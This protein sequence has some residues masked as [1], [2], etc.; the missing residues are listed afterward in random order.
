M[1][2]RALTVSVLTAGLSAGLLAGAL[3]PA[4]AQ[5]NPVGGQGNVYFLSGAGN[6]T[7]QAEKVSVFGD[8]NDEVYFGDWDKD[9]TDSPMVR[10]GN[11]FYVADEDGK[12]VSV[13]AYGD[14]G[15]Q[16]LIG[17]WNG[18]GVDSIAV[19]RANKFFVKNDNQ[20]TG[21]ADSTF[22]YGD[23]GDTVLVGD[24][25]GDKKDTLIVSR[26]DG[27][28]HVK[29]DTESGV[30][31]YKFLFGNPNDTILVGDWATGGV[32][33]DGHDQIAVRRGFEYHLSEELGKDKTALKLA[34]D[35][36]PYGNPDDTVFVASMPYTVKDANGQ[37]VLDEKRTATYDADV[38]A[39]FKGGELKWAY[40]GS[41]I[42][43]PQAGQNVQAK[44]PRQ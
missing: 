27:V 18:D 17:D 32:D 39:T 21:T 24:W 1:S 31:E 40:D 2:K 43:N 5:G 3:S 8:P 12:T 22:Y 36:M 42:N 10:R 34:G 16:V 35:V 33:A 25:D 7:G 14:A 13:F 15:D 29:N 37:P 11:V 9:G 44:S 26:N 28:F 38:A 19:R 4:A 30:A 41:A 23:A 6:P 20:K